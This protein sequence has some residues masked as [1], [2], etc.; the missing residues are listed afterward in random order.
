MKS[1][2]K[3]WM[4][5]KF[6]NWKDAKVHILTHAL[7]YGTAVFEGMRCYNTPKGPA[8]F[9]MTEHYQRLENG[10]KSYQLKLGYNVRQMCGITRK[11]IRV[12]KV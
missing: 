12:N 11:L 2:K 3:I 9:R 4:D 8:V 5:G 6:I 1:L 10:C 7:H